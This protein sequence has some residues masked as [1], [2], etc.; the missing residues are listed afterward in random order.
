MTCRTWP[1]SPTVTAASITLGVAAGPSTLHR[2]PAAQADVIRA[3]H[4]RVQLCQ[5]PQTEFV[6]FVKVLAS[7]ASITF[8]ECTATRSCK[9]NEPLKFTTRWDSDL[10][11]GSSWVSRRT[12]W[13][14]SH[15]A[16]ACPESSTRGRE[17]SRPAHLGAL[18]AAKPRIQ[19]MTQDA[20]TAGLLPKQPLENSPC[21]G[22][23]NSHLP[24]R[25]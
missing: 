14:K 20:V 12:V 24:Q 23:R 8:C 7:V 25:P 18:T 2:G 4:E 3:M 11:R 6:I 15:S 19:A 1:R 22:Y 13:H 16:K 10:S 5:D 21:R 17:T 9:S